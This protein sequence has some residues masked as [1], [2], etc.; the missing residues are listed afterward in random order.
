M[1]PPR[2]KEL[3]LGW[4]KAAGAGFIIVFSVLVLI[5]IIVDHRQRTAS[6]DPKLSEAKELDLE[7][8]QVVAEPDKYLEKH[9]AWCVQNRSKNEVF[10]RGDPGRRLTVFNHERMPVVTGSK[11]ASCEKMLLQL[12]GVRKLSSGSGIAGVMFISAL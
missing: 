8:D 1:I 4:L 3:L 7:F 6:L 10:Y 11:H 5:G 2:H 9:V 12:K